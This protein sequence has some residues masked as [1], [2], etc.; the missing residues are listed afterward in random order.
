MLSIIS[1]TFSWDTSIITLGTVFA[2]FPTS[3]PDLCFFLL[4][5]LIWVL[6][7][8][9]K[10]GWM[11]LI[12]DDC[13]TTGVGCSSKIVIFYLFNLLI[14]CGELGPIGSI[15]L[16]NL[17]LFFQLPS[18]FPYDPLLCSPVTLTSTG[19]E[20]SWEKISVRNFFQLMSRFLN[21]WT[22]KIFISPWW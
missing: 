21:S 15:V 11:F 14:D 1:P 9:S 19:L 3:F 5:I 17:C 4:F 13:A 20:V 22:N 16:L 10:S 2:I 12:L 7:F 6:H 18:F 8:V